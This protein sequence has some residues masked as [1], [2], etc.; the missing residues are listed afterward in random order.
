MRKIEIIKDKVPQGIDYS[1]TLH[2]L[3]GKNLWIGTYNFGLFSYSLATNEFNNF[4]VADGLPSS[5]IV[6]IEEDNNGNLWL[7]TSYGLAKFNTLDYKVQTFFINEGVNNYQFHE[8][9]SFKGKDGVIYFGGNSGLTYFYPLK[10]N[11]EAL[12]LLGLSLKN[13]IS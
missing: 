13:Y 10:W 3:D 8:K 7:S 5:D 11:T 9:S 2:C 4:S 6:G 12:N 1:I